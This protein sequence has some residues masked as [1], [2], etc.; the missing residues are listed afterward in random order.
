MYHTSLD[1]LLKNILVKIAHKAIHE[2]S[3]LQVIFSDMKKSFDQ[4]MILQVDIAKL[5]FK[6]GTTYIW[7]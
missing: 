1:I 2:M 4:C 7:A 5:I 3:K 6:P